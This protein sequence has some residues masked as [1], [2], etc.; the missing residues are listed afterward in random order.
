MNKNVTTFYDLNVEQRKL[1]LEVTLG[2]KGKCCSL[3]GG[4]CGEIFVFDQGENHFPR[5]VCAKVPK[6][7][8]N[9][10]QEDTAKRF[11][12]ELEKQLSVYRHMFVHWP[13][14]FTE[15]MGAPVA[16]F[17][18]WESDLD[19]LIK[20]NS[21]SDIQWLSIMIYTCVGLRH[22]YK[23]GLI[24]HQDLKPANIFL[25]DVKKSC[26][27][28][29]NLDIY[30]FAKIADFGLSNAARES[31]I[32]DGTRPYMAPEQWYK[33]ELSAATDVFAIGVIL[34][35]LISGGYHPVGIKLQD[36]WPS[37][38]EGNSKKWTRENSWRKWVESG[39]KIENSTCQLSRDLL[40]LI[41][42]MLSLKP[43]ERPSMDEVIAHLLRQIQ[44]LSNASYE[45]VEFL[46]SYFDSEAC[47]DPLEQQWPYLSE[48][49]RQFSIKFG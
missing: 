30:L 22:C 10:T 36:F 14:D 17:R 42:G 7:L 49:W 41:Q 3:S 45:Q 26:P 9:A 29:P 16:L 40:T 18:Y 4:L 37:P 19:Q 11:V 33:E 15:V 24:A 25:R 32:F 35:E 38:R 21:V 1:M 23:N 44:T 34:Y 6:R 27:G 8:G 39:C 28:L 12:N 47:D 13:F 48:V 46:V 20:D 5:Y 2:N 31:N 43:S